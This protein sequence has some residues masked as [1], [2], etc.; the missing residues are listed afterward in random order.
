MWNYNYVK[1]KHLDN[2]FSWNLHC[3]L[4]SA[5]LIVKWEKMKNKWK[6]IEKKH[7]KNRETQDKKKKKR[8]G[9]QNKNKQTPLPC[10]KTKPKV[11][12]WLEIT[13]LGNSARNSC[14]Q[15]LS[16]PSEMEM[17]ICHHS[18]SVTEIRSGLSFSSSLDHGHAGRQIALRGAR[19]KCGCGRVR[20]HIYTAGGRISHRGTFNRRAFWYVYI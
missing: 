14:L 20:D 15:Q 8:K 1:T 13:G 18:G 9:K 17:E 3:Y 11:I 5:V 19:L 2:L 4:S 12:N 7:H 10:N 16:R 6:Q